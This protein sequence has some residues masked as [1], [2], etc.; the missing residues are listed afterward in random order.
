MPLKETSYLTDVCNL[1]APGGIARRIGNNLFAHAPGRDSGL[2][3]PAGQA[4]HWGSKMEAG[5]DVN[6]APPQ[7]VSAHSSLPALHFPVHECG[8]RGS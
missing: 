3:R 8:L 7:H 5:R 4:E 6:P 2:R 1:A